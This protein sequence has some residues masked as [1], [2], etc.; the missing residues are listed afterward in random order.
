MKT[1][2]QLLLFALLL[3]TSCKKDDDSMI[4]NRAPEAFSLLTME[5]QT[6][7]AP[8]TPTFTWQS[9]TDSD[10]D[11]VVYD[12]YLE[13]RGNELIVPILGEGSPPADPT[14][15]IA[16]GITETTFTPTEQ[17]PINN[18]FTWKVV[19]R[20]NQGGAVESEIFRFRTRILNVSEEPLTLNA[21]FD[22]R[23]G[24]GSVFFNDRFW[25]IGG[26]ANIED[27]KNDVWSSEDGQ[28]WV[29]ETENTAFSGRA[30]FGI[31]VFQDRMFIL[32]GI[33]NGT[34]SNE[35]WSS[36]DGVTWELEADNPDFSPRAQTK[37]VS[38]Q[39][40]LYA[41]G[42]LENIFDPSTG[43]ADDIWSS[44]NGRDWVQETDT[45]PFLER[46]GFEA[47]VFND[48]LF[49]IAG[50]LAN[51]FEMTNDVWYTRDGQNWIQAPTSNKFGRRAFLKSVVFSGKLW[52]TGGYFQ[53]GLD[54]IY[55]TDFYS[56]SDGLS[57][58]RQILDASYEARYSPT[59]V[60]NQDFMLLIAGGQI[61][62]N[63]KF[64]DVWKFD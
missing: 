60:S 51:G 25:V 56:S 62:T 41:I 15:I 59:L 44:T 11:A 57:W 27:S 13:I 1:T 63:T 53:E 17:L 9:A 22:V 50:A 16:Q 29:L 10:G 47:I 32:G 20:D 52:M 46:F 5:D 42:G 8:L 19:A 26:F 39:D 43:S 23:Q 37:L 3:S 31:T 14:L 18:Q 6:S 64:N 54:E 55:Y 58:Q 24:H 48:K 12:L 7:D 4:P 45:A 61:A 34:I 2:L 49:V 35:V 38:F 40:K 28:N 21:P 33:G 36:S 30:H